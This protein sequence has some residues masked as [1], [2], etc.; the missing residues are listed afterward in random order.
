MCST[1]MRSAVARGALTPHVALVPESPSVTL[2]D[3]SAVAAAIQKQMTPFT[4]YNDVVPDHRDPK[5][6]GGAWRDDHPDNIQ[7]AHW[8]CNSEKGSTRMGD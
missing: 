6:M 2:A 4:D 5:G 8:W 1:S 3:V 7:A